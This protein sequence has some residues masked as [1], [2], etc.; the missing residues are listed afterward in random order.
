[1]GTHAR[2][3]AQSTGYFVAFVA[4]CMALQA[5]FDYHLRKPAEPHEIQVLLGN[6]KR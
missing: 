4:T 5:G 2:G 1:M 3:P 6:A